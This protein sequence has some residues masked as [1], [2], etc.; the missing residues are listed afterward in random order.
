MVVSVRIQA[1]TRTVTRMLN[2]MKIKV[3]DAA[4]KGGWELGKLMQTN[5]RESL[6]HNKLINT[7][8]LYNSV[9]AVKKSKKRTEIKMLK[10]GEYLDSAK[11]HFVPLRFK[12]GRLRSG[13]S[14]VKWAQSAKNSPFKNRYLPAGF[15]FKPHPWIDIAISRSL[16]NLPK[17]MKERMNKAIKAR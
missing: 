1:D 4:D 8:N 15:W 17:I 2:N 9:L 10:Y 11:P 6:V 16:L 14:A 13:S 12:N 5:L 3:P 7:T